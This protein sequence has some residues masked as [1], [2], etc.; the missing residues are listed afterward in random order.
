MIGGN[1]DFENIFFHQV[2]IGLDVFE[3]RCVDEEKELKCK[4]SL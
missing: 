4:A 3:A 2:T 1:K